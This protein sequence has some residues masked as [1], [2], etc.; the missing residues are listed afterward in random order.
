MALTKSAHRNAAKDLTCLD[1]DVTLVLEHYIRIMV[2]LRCGCYG[3]IYILFRRGHLQVL[4]C[5]GLVPFVVWL[6]GG[7]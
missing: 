7:H 1:D 6:D 2:Y 3:S 4:F 5:E